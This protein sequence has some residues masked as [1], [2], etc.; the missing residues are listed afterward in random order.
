MT[1]IFKC[2]LMQ[3]HVYV[4]GPQLSILWYII[5]HIVFVAGYGSNY[6]FILLFTL[7][8]PEQM[9]NDALKCLDPIF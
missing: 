5:V 6:L 7:S 9:P 4:T 8:R 3:L 1:S 2:V